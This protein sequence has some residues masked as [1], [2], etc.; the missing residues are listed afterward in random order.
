MSV[1][2][3]KQYRFERA[4]GVSQ[5]VRAGILV[6]VGLAV[7]WL[8]SNLWRWVSLPEVSVVPRIVFFVGVFIAVS[9]VICIPLLLIAL[10]VYKPMVIEVDEMGLRCTR[11]GKAAQNVK[12]ADVV[13]YEP[14][15]G[16]LISFEALY[17]NWGNSSMSSHSNYDAGSELFGCLI[18]IVLGLYFLVLETF[19]GTGS[20]RVQFKM[21]SKRSVNVFGYGYAMDELVQQVLP[22]VL[23]NKRKAVA[24]EQKE[25]AA[26]EEVES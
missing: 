23:P 19:I 21:K 8:S 5:F 12:W 13:W 15:V 18:G 4:A 7:I 10:R 6:A 25:P 2:L 9:G 24:A 11:E 16:G 17:A 3:P 1:Q 14:D 22:Q 20:W 26:D